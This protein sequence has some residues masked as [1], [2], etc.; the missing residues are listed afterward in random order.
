[1]VA[2]LFAD[3][4]VHAAFEL[5]SLPVCDL[6][7]DFMHAQLQRTVKEL[8]DT[9]CNCHPQKRGY[10]SHAFNKNVACAPPSSLGQDS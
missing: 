3:L 2:G 7:F 4:A 8:Q 9:Y 6:L 5:P 1:M 10:H